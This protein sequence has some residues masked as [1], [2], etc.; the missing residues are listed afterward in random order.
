M[1]IRRRNTPFRRRIAQKVENTF[2]PFRRRKGVIRRRIAKKVIPSTL[3]A[4]TSKTKRFIERKSF[5]TNQL[6]KDL[7]INI[8]SNTVLMFLRKFSLYDLNDQ[9]RGYLRLVLRGKKSKKN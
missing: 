3:N 5:A 7:L 1:A 6:L 2:F 4:H 8:Y 9:N